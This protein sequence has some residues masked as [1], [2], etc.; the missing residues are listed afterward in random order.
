[1][2]GFGLSVRNPTLTAAGGEKG[3]G[4]FSLSASAARLKSG[5]GG[6]LD[7]SRTVTQLQGLQGGAAGSYSSQA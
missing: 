2:A 5:G 6:D 7:A 3:K 1:M 4:P